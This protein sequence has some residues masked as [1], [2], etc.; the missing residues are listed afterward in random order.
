[1]R[2]LPLV[3]ALFFV[4][5]LQ[6]Q[7][8]FDSLLLI[9]SDKIYFD[10]GKYDLRPASDSTLLEVLTFCKDKEQTYIHLTAHTDA[11]GSIPYN[12]TLSQ[13]RGNAASAF[14][15]K[16]GWNADR[17]QVN[18][19]GE[20]KPETENE[21]AE[22]RQQNRRV[23][24]DVYQKEKF[25]NI[26]GTVKDQES[27]EGIQADIVIRTKEWQ[28]SISTDTSGKFQFAV[29]DSTILGL[30]IYAEGHFFDTRMIKAL[31]GKVPPLDIDLQPAN[32]G[33]VADIKNL[34]YVGDQAILLPKSEPELPK[35]LKFMEIN[36]R[37]KIEIAGHINLPN[38]R[39]VPENTWHFKLSVRRAKLV[40]DYLIENGINPERLQYKG[41]GNSKMRF[42]MGV[43]QN[44]RLR[45]EG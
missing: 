25:V 34:Y 6:A 11:V 20:E 13:N 30:D 15:L 27:G 9:R 17:I 4:F 43:P 44:N 42:P 10:P 7:L 19:Y 37:I 36:P 14:L 29:P 35:I 3:L 33:E 31:A 8:P 41:Y 18:E 26:S 39:A 32:E 23:T 1:M 12:Q 21:T 28:D 5:N 45:T 40:Y 38:Q 16:N 22:G 24:V 2:K